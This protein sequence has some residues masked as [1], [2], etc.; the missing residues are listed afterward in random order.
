MDQF[1]QENKPKNIPELKSFVVDAYK[2][3]N[4]SEL[5]KAVLSWEKRLHVCVQEGGDRFEHKL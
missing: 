1:V 2:K 3:I 4:L 5:Q